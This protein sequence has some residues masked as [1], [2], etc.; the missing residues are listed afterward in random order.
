VNRHY[1]KW[2]RTRRE[3]TVGRV[4][5]ELYPDAA[6]PDS[7]YWREYHRC[8]RERAAVHFVAY[9]TPLAFWADVRGYPTADGGI[10]VFIRDVSAEKKAEETLKHQSDFEQHLIGIVSH[11][12]RSPLTTIALA[13]NA[14]TRREELDERAMKGVIRISNAAE[15]ATRLV[16]DLLD[17]TQARLGG[18][19]RIQRTPVELRAALKSVL[20]EAEA[21]WPS[22]KL[23]VRCEGAT[24]GKWDP[25][26]LAQVLQ[27]LVTNALKYSPDDSEVSV[28]THGE[29][30][31]VEIAVHNGGPPIPGEML[32]SI[33]EPLR[34]G[35]NTGG[36]PG[37]S[38]GLGLYIVKELVE[39]HGGNVRVRSGEAEGTTFT[40][41]LPLEP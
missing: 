5:W 15:R 11:D 8:V 1:E 27:N 4:F 40:V 26:R 20:E 17:F 3:D 31:F 34:R 12:L 2:T 16:N 24:Q 14:L 37:R 41:R 39:A 25:D 38:V 32:P 19:I 22:R 36:V 33:F 18:G 23:S 6:R 13:S 30:G 35:D 29:G 7:V 9:Y 28:V 21:A 10:A